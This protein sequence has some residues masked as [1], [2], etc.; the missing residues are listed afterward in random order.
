[1]SLFAASVLALNTCG[2]IPRPEA[3][4]IKTSSCHVQGFVDPTEPGVRQFLGIPFAHPPTGSRRWQPPSKLQSA[5]PLNATSIGPACP[6]QPLSQTNGLFMYVPPGGNQTEFF[7]PETSQALSEDCL[8]LNVWA[9]A[10]ASSKQHLPVLVWFFGGGF[11]R[12]GTNAKYF[13]PRSWVG[14]SQSHIVVTVNF[15]SNIF[16]FPNAH[17]LAHQNLGLFDQRLALEWVQENIAGFGGD[18]ERIVLWGQSAGA[19][20][21]DYLNFAYPADPIF[22]GLILESGTALYSPKLCQSPDKDGA[23]FSAVAKAFNCDAA[24]SP[25]DC[26][27]HVPWQDL[28]A[29]LATLGL[30]SSFL[31]VVDQH[32]VFSDYPE[33]YKIGAFSSVP[34]LIGMNQHEVNALISPTSAEASNQTYVDKLSNATFLCP[35]AMASKYRQDAGY[36]TYRYR[37]DGDFPS[38]SY[39]GVPGAYHAADL[40]LIFGTAGDYHGASTA[41]EKKVGHAMQDM[42]LEF[43]KDP[44]N[45]LKN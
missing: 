1:M 37:Y 34:A 27:R 38:L 5:Q 42:W 2:T 12:G 40:P 15:R 20:A 18:P 23:N 44:V 22:S 39:P 19:I 36:A 35:A 45:G 32:L 29:S 21:S 30:A 3:L 26:L 10:T 28:Q 16:G 14:R 4:Q 11:V 9:P 17:G 8:T 25:V 33:R 41:Y 24:P 13:N 43:A 31:P 6:Q 7:S